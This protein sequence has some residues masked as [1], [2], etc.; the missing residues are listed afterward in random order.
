MEATQIVNIF[1]SP[2]LMNQN[3]N[4]TP[5]L[6]EV[7]LFFFEN[8]EIVVSLMKTALLSVQLLGLNIV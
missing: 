1:L 3:Y 6:D 7:E 4:V 5:T 2:S 8:S